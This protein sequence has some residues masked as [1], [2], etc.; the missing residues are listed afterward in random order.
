MPGALAVFGGPFRDKDVAICLL[1]Q[2]SAMLSVGLSE[3][4]GHV[5]LA[6]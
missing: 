4:Y 2:Y 5:G 6:N 1:V 3:M